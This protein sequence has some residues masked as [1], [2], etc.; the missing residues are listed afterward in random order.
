[1]PIKSHS[2]EADLCSCSFIAGCEHLRQ[3]FLEKQRRNIDIVLDLL[4]DD[5]FS[6]SYQMEI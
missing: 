2:I 6:M 1:V 5:R 3:L 4:V